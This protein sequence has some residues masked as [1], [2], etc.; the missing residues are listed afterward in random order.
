[1][2]RLPAAG[3]KSFSPRKW[4]D[5]GLNRHDGDITLPKLSIHINRFITDRDPLVL[6]VLIAAIVG[7]VSSCTV[8]LFRFVLYGI[9]RLYSGQE[10]LVDLNLVARSLICQDRSL[11]MRAS[12]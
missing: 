7:F 3:W 8:E 12:I 6:M 5:S 4:N 1:M 10:H 9:V 2:E 11:Y